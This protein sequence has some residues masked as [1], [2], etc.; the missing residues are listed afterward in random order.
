M[1][2]IE[3]TLLTVTNLA[4]IPALYVC[5]INGHYGK[6]IS[7]SLATLA[8][9]NYH[10]SEPKRHTPHIEKMFKSITSLFSPKPTK[11]DLKSE[12]KSDIKLKLDQ[13]FAI[14]CMVT[15]ANG[16]FIIDYGV[17][18]ISLL[19]MMIASDLV[20]W[21]PISDTK[22]II[23]RLILHCPWHIGALGYLPYVYITNPKYHSN[24]F[25]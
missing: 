3:K 25:F 21:V 13:I 1:N 12:S 23:L 20:Y 17:H 19:G 4:S 9:I 15:F 7:L 6:F 5:A 2:S 8:S 16:D 10:S 24:L 11:I 22:Q 14:W 18:I